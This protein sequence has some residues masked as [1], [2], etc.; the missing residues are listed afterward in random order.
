MNTDN[1]DE[2]LDHSKGKIILAGILAGLGKGFGY[3]VLM[4]NIRAIDNEIIK[5]QKILVDEMRSNYVQRRKI[6]FC[7]DQIDILI[8]KKQSI[9]DYVDNHYK[10]A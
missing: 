5:Y 6:R 7:M 4:M 3:S 10:E 2:K 8:S 1:K 9:L